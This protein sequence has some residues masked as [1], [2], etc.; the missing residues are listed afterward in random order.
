[1]SLS[2]FTNVLID[3]NVKDF[4]LAISV[5]AVVMMLNIIVQLCIV[6]MI[7]KEQLYQTV[8]EILSDGLFWLVILLNT[9]L[10]MLPFMLFRRCSSL[11]C[12][13]RQYS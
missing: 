7:A 9:F 11:I 1:M 4:N 8:P 3:T 13:K 5:I 12:S 10:L 6:N 2:I